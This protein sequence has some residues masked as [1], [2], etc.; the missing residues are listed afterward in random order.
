M[1]N[2]TKASGRVPFVL[3]GDMIRKKKS[4]KDTLK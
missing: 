4:K 2:N 3:Q 1:G